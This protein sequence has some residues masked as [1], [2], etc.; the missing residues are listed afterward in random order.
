MSDIYTPSHPVIHPFLRYGSPPDEESDITKERKK[1]ERENANV[2]SL[3]TESARLNSLIEQKNN[4]MSKIFENQRFA[5]TPEMREKQAAI[6]AEISTFQTNLRNVNEQLREAQDLVTTRAQH[7]YAEMEA[8]ADAQMKLNEQ[9]AREK[10]MVDEAIERDERNNLYNSIEQYNTLL[11]KYQKA[12]RW[13]K[14]IKSKTQIPDGLDKWR[15]TDHELENKE[16]IYE[17]K[18]NL[19]STYG[20][21]FSGLNLDDIIKEYD[22]YVESVARKTKRSMSPTP[23]SR[24]EATG[25]KIMNE[26]RNELPPST[27]TPRG[28]FRAWGNSILGTPFGK[29][30]GRRS[31][32]KGKKGTRRHSKKKSTRRH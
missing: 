17:K 26:N 23:T 31:K 13:L 6:Q 27:M 11:E 28:Y 29:K 9:R 8:R 19:Q 24:D 7:N 14:H 15:L 2:N 10:A 4:E 5:I 3:A 32:K 18:W 30:G 21:Y 16:L 1:A 20:R 12:A 22:A 25:V